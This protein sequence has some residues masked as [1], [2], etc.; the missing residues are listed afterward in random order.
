ML[1]PLQRWVIL[2]GHTNDA[3]AEGCHWTT[4]EDFGGERDDA[5]AVRHCRKQF[6][7]TAIEEVE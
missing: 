6:V 1:E 7:V 3:A 2:A 5:D 4:I